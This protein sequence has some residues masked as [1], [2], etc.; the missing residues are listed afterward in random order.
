MP[1]SQMFHFVSAR[2]QASVVIALSESL[3][4]VSVKL[5]N[6]NLDFNPAAETL[7]ITFRLKPVDLHPLQ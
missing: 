4:F 5:H 6:T 2:H 7:I 1:L 3:A